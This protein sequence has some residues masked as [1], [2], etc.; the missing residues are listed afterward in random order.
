MFNCAT[1]RFN[2]T[3]ATRIVKTITAILRA[4]VSHR[5]SQESKCPS[6]Q[7]YEHALTTWNQSWVCWGGALLFSSLFLRILCIWASP[8]KLI[9]SSWSCS[10][11]LGT[12]LSVFD[13]LPSQSRLQVQN[14]EGNLDENWQKTRNNDGQELLWKHKTS[15]HRG[16]AGRG[17]PQNLKPCC[18]AW[19]LTEFPCPCLQR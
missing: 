4:Q 10:S 1:K 2:S 19:F 3:T 7:K 14:I 11:R 16:C 9:P 5:K 6:R 17:K 18:P 15:K 12:C 13:V 8:P